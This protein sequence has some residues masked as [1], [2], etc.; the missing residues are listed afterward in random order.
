[1]GGVQIF[2]GYLTASAQTRW[3]DKSGSDTSGNGTFGA[4]YA[5]VQKALD[6]ITDAASAKPYRIVVGVGT[7]TEAFL[8]KPWCF[9]VGSGR[10]LTTLSPVQ[11]NWIS[12]GFAGAAAQDAGIAGCSIAS[13]FLVDFNAVGSTGAG[14]FFLYEVAAVGVSISC[15][16]G[17]TASNAFFSQDVQ[18]VSSTAGLTHLFTDVGVLT[19]A[20]WAIRSNSLTITTTGAYA[21]FARVAGIFQNSPG[22]FTASG[23]TVST[24]I[25]SVFLDTSQ[26]TVLNLSL[27][28]DGVSCTG[29]G[30]VYSVVAAD[31]DN[32]F[33]TTAAQAGATPL[34][35][36]GVNLIRAN[37]T[38]DRTFTF[39]TPGEGT[40]FVIKNQSTKYITVA[41][42]SAAPGSETYCGPQGYVNMLFFSAANWALQNEPQSGTTVLVNGLSPVIVADVAAGSRVVAT[43]KTWNGACGVPQVINRIVGSRASTGSFQIQSTDPAT[44]AVVATDQGAYD[45]I[46]IY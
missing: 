8:V 24:A 38:A 13:T 32:N 41:P 11:A 34:V 35:G 3:V 19:L 17:S 14:R 36:G 12:A 22:V 15:K 6:S 30:L 25:N 46:A 9:I 31:A 2:P 29:A 5:T 26:T 27:V 44:G 1:M 33:S 7:F 45:W 37:P 42:T 10:N 4:P 39:H 18:Q 40:R 16:G 43:L 21:C 28:G 23:G 20:N